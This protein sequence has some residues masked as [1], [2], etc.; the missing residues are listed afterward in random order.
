M[1]ESLLDYLA[2]G[3][4]CQYLSDLSVLHDKRELASVL[5][6]AQSI[7]FPERDWIDACEYITGMQ[8]D[9]KEDAESKLIQFCKK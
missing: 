4:H 8:S 6:N 5:S 2:V 3:M 9:N 1:K 7:P